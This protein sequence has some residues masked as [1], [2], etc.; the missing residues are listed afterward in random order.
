MRHKRR[1][2][3]LRA[4]IETAKASRA[5]AL[6]S[7][8][9]VLIAILST[10]VMG[11]QIYQAYQTDKPI[12]APM[13]TI[14]LKQGWLNIAFKN[15]GA[16]PAFRTRAR[17][18]LCG[19]NGGPLDVLAFSESPMDRME[20]DEDRILKITSPDLEKY[21]DTFLLISWA[22][23]SYTNKRYRRFKFYIYNRN[24]EEW[25]TGSE[26]P[27]SLHISPFNSPF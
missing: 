7:W 4:T 14:S 27:H 20:R 9:M 2:I 26:D 12:I 21:S 25:V 1:V 24:S 18:Q 17:L 13:N 16:W 23:S 15:L 10:L 22:Y 3:E 5:M 11:A 6:A 19:T 8:A